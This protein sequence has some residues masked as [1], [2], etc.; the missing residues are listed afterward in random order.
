M[1]VH[2][3]T[4]V[5]NYEEKQRSKDNDDSDSLMNKSNSYDTLKL[6]KAKPKIDSNKIQEKV[7]LLR[8]VSEKKN[9][10]PY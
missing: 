4:P 8:E 6:F 9:S 2:E 1:P 3:S 5:K 7:Y 10:I